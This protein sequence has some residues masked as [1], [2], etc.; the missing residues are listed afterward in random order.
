MEF[1]LTDDSLDKSE[2]LGM[3]FMDLTLVPKYD[4]NETDNAAVRL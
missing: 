2:Y 3:I 1:E 4:T